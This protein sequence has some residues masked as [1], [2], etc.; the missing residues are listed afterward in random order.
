[1]SG[2]REIAEA[3]SA[4]MACGLAAVAGCLLAG[5]A[6]ALA[7]GAARRWR[8]AQ[9]AAALAL[10]AGWS[11]YVGGAKPARGLS[12]SWD[13]GLHD[14]G[15]A[16]SAD[17]PNALTVRWTFDSWVPPLSTVTLYACPPG[18]SNAVEIADAPM[19]NLS[20]T[21][22]M[23]AA[24]T[25]YAYL[26][27]HSYVPA[28]SVVTNGV[29][30]IDCFANASRTWVPKGVTAYGVAEGADGVAIRIPISY[31]TNAVPPTLGEDA[32]LSTIANGLE[33]T[34]D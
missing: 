8:R 34:N 29:Y 13:E 5:Y 24:A 6:V 30:R 17:D 2:A 10:A 3:V 31:D 20:I 22:L 26:V 4:W 14:A 15:S 27:T 11:L 33:E 21:V 19:T 32:D 1:M 28:P 18:G 9:C 23:A 12:I 16:V 7:V 25:N